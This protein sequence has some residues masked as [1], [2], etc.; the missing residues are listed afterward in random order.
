M[1]EN[2]DKLLDQ[3]E[4]KCPILKDKDFVNKYPGIENV[5][6]FFYSAMQRK[7]PNAIEKMGLT[8]K[9][10]LNKLNQD[11]KKAIEIYEKTR[12]ILGFK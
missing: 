1:G 4:K 5:A 7:I 6:S 9:G 12:N 3:M 10:Y 11:D 2:I 8:L